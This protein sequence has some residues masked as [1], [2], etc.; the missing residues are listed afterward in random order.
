MLADEGAG[1][2]E[3]QFGRHGEPNNTKPQQ[4]KNLPVAILHDLD[5]H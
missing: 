4:C 5:K 2:R 1:T 3:P